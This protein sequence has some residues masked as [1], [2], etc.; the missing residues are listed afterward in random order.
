MGIDLFIPFIGVAIPEITY[1]IIL[2]LL[3]LT[4]P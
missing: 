1:H 2:Y 3:L 4:L